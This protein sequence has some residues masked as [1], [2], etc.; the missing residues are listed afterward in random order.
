MTTPPAPRRRDDPRMQ[1]VE[2]AALNIPGTEEEVFGSGPVLPPLPRWQIA[3]LIAGGGAVGAVLR[4]LLQLLLPSTTTPTLVEMP[5]STLLANTL[6]CLAMGLLAGG[7]QVRRDAPRWLFPAVGTGMIGGFTT[8]STVVLEGS[9]MIGAEFPRLALL[10]GTLTVLLAV[11]AIM[12]GLMVGRVSARA[13]GL[14]RLGPT[15]RL[16]GVRPARLQRPARSGHR[17]RRVE[18][19]PTP[20][21]EDAS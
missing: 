5:W 4:F 21:E 3:L 11:V 14:A 10:Y 19:A 1:T 8:F 9:A 7:I 20:N 16:A 15:S 6:G 13:A 18:P 17:R 2:M 12:V